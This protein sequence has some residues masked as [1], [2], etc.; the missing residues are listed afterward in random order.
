MHC[1]SNNQHKAIVNND[2]QKRIMEEYSQWK[3]TAPMLYDMVITHNL[4]WPT[5]TCQWLPKRAV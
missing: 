1:Y 4:T 3:K 5:L 2:E